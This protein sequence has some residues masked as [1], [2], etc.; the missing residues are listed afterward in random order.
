M[1]ARRV[2]P[3]DNVPPRAN[4]SPTENRASDYAGVLLLTGSLACLVLSISEGSDW[5][6]TNP[7]IVAA[8]IASVVAGAVFIRRCLRH[9]QP[10]LDL[11]LFRTRS[12]TVANAATTTY[13][14]GFFALLLGS[15]LFLTGVWHYSVLKAGL[16]L[17]PAPLVVVVISG[18]AGRTAARVGFRPLVAVGATVLAGGISWFAVALG[19]RPDYVSDWLPGYLMIGLGVA[20]TLPV[21]SAAAASCLPPAQF[22]VGSAV[23]Q[24]CRQVGGA[25][26]IA[27]LVAILGKGSLEVDTFRH[28]WIYAAVMAGSTGAISLLLRAKAPAATIPL[29]PDLPSSKDC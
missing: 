24:T 8:A 13:A 21:L 7:R 10:V 29:L 28:L 20:L 4:L 6:W 2:L 27:I 9:P 14:M 19:A 15:V 18:P 23:N 1:S 12:F 16:A 5:G 26:G 3:A 11:S 17:T 25:L 22:A